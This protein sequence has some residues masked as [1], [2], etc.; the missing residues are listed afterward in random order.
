MYLHVH[1][2]V[3]GHSLLP[4]ARKVDLGLS[5]FGVSV[6]TME[7]VFIQ[8][9]RGTDETLESRLVL[10]MLRGCQW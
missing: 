7:E 5:S 4:V 6:T 2:H 8:V 9:G 10:D 3:R 1:V